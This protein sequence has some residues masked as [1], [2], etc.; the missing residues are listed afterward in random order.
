MKNIINDILSSPAIINSY[1]EDPIAY[2][3][4]HLDM[5]DIS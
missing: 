1:L 5:T 3:S 4:T 2:S